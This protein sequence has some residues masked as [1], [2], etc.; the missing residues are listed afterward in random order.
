MPETEDL[1]VFSAVFEKECKKRKEVTIIVRYNFHDA[2]YFDHLQVMCSCKRSVNFV[3]VFNTDT[4]CVNVIA[5]IVIA[6]NIPIP[7][8]SKD[9]DFSIW[10]PIDL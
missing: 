5:L 7:Y 4:K 2:I 8:F 9:L 10:P 6:L 1:R 3:Y